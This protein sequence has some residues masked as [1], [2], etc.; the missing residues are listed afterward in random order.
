MFNG[1]LT[2][3]FRVTDEYWKQSIKKLSGFF[4]YPQCD[5]VPIGRKKPMD[6]IDIISGTTSVYASAE[7][8]E[9]F[10]QANDYPITWEV[11]FLNDDVGKAF[12]NDINES[13]KSLHKSD[14][15]ILDTDLS[16]NEPVRCIEC[17]FKNKDS[18]RKIMNQVFS[19]RTFV[20][21]SKDQIV[22]KI[23]LLNNADKIIQ[24]S[25]A[26]SY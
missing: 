2:E 21:E 26:L 15:F 18:F 4:C 19:N 23:Q 6:D 12:A 9:P 1:T 10:E 14:G 20:D 5:I 25:A 24:P 11:I 8:K 22:P 13:F 7:M 3:R 16:I 17:V